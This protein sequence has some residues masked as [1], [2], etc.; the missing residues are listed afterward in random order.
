MITKIFKDDN[1]EIIL[2]KDYLYIKNYIKINDLN[3]NKI[4]ITLKNIIINISGND[5]LIFKMD[6][7]DIGIKGNI[8][9]ID[10]IDE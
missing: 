4:N 6:K 2:N 1:Y 7:Y 8:K 9:G 10:F 3:S 5:L